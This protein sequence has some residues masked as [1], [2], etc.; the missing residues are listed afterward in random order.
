MGTNPQVTITADV[1]TWRP[2]LRA[3]LEQ[4]I[5]DFDAR[6]TGTPTLSPKP[7]MEDVTELVMT[8]WTVKAYTEAMRTL[9]A[10]GHVVQ[11]QAIRAAVSSGTGLVSRED[12]YALGGYDESRTLKGFTRPVNRIQADLVDR[13]LLDEE[14][15][16][17]LEP[18][19]PPVT[20]YAR[21]TAF[22]VPMEV[23][24]LASA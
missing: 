19:Y 14:S 15:A 7:E 24:R 21:A 10:G 2:E 9:S 11:V 5:R 4:T 3:Q 23:V 16:D 13:G 17:L 6:S 20:G 18:V 12:V 8:G 1:T 22:R